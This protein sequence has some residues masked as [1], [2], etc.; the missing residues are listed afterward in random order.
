[1]EERPELPWDWMT[2]EIFP[3]LGHST[4]LSLFHACVDA[5]HPSGSGWLFVQL[6]FKMMM[7]SHMQ[8][9]RR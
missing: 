4:L 1:V 8:M 3:G 6:T 5:E 2:A 9:R 7:Q